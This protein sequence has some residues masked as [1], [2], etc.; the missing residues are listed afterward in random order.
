MGLMRFMKL[1]I[2]LINRINFIN[3]HNCT[4]EN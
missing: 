2:N 4:L 3:P 1:I